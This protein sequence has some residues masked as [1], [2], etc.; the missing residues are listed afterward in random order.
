MST[1]SRKIDSLPILAQVPIV[2]IDL[3]FSMAGKLSFFFFLHVFRL[4]FALLILYLLV[5]AVTSSEEF[6][7]ILHFYEFLHSF[8]LEGSLHSLMTS[9]DLH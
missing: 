6:I 4:Y 2:W 9:L 7:S 5:P 1:M 8:C 3:P